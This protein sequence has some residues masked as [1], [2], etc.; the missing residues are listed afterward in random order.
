MYCVFFFVLFIQEFNENKWKVKRENERFEKTYHCEMKN[1][2]RKEKRKL[3]RVRI[4]TTLDEF[5]IA[6]HWFAS[7]L[8]SYFPFFTVS[9]LS[10]ILSLLFEQRKCINRF[11]KSN[12]LESIS[13]HFLND[14]DKMMC[15]WYTK[16]A[17]RTDKMP[18]TAFTFV[19]F[20]SA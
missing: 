16:K 4:D 3:L 8:S 5:P 17:T 2:T 7:C 12:F 11:R 13:F 15:S 10:L 18:S 1:K 20:V 19:R 6:K 14:A 9:S